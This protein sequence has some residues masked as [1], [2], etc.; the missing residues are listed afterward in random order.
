MGG[1]GEQ[2]RARPVNFR[3]P[4]KSS[5]RSSY[6]DGL[7]VG[8]GSN[9]VAEEIESHEQEHAESQLQWMSFSSV[10]SSGSYPSSTSS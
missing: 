1:D 5:V 7:A 10:A 3:N 6:A 9:E 4:R 8:A 2:R